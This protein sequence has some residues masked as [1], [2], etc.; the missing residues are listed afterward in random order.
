MNELMS[1]VEGY[2]DEMVETLSALIERKAVSPDFG[3]DGELEKAEYLM[4]LLD[5]FEI[6]ERFDAKDERAKGGVRP[7]IVA[8][9]KGALDKTVWIVTHIDVVPEGDESLWKT[10]PFKAVVKDG[11][12]YGRGT[13]DNGQS[14]V[15][16]LY[17]AKAVLKLGLTP[18]YTLGL[19]FVSDEE[20]GSRYGIQH[21]IKEG[22]FSKED[23]IVVPDVGTP[24][25]DGIEI[26]EKSLLWLK[27]TVHGT[28]SHASLPTGLNA[29][30]RAMRFI[31]DLDE[32]LHTKFNAKN[33]I[34]I[35]ETSTFEPTKREKNVDNVNTIPGLDISYMDCRVLP[36]YDLDEVIDFVESIRK[37]HEMRDNER[38]DI[39]VL[40]KEESPPTPET[41]EIVLKLRNTIE[42]LRGTKTYVYGIG[43]N[44][45]AAFFRKAG[46]VNTAAW[47][48][49]EGVAHQPNEYCVIRNMVEDAKVFALLPF[50]VGY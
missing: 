23:F 5:D 6:V 19:V 10:P 36:E 9:I 37:F 32:K 43:G 4:K 26:A 30:R 44:T 12:I 1:I 29:S 14:V 13:E 15:S 42:K 21:L 45:C 22:V 7:N 25:G 11:R 39:E 3:G 31:L 28:Q 35:P 2:Q 24:K 27:F 8:K 47:S 40:Q 20:S 50:D 48:T 49:V 16:S 46:F 34:F 33:K 38:I 18:K 17:A 41:S